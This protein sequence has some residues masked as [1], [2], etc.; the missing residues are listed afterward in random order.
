MKLD[1]LSIIRI[2]YIK[3]FGKKVKGNLKH[4]DG[5]TDIITLAKKGIFK[6][7]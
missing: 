3:I 6:K 1:I 4:T 2:Y 5:R 7:F